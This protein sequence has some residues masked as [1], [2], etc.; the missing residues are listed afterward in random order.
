M[1]SYRHVFLLVV[2]RLFAEHL[3]SGGSVQKSCSLM[4]LEVLVLREFLKSHSRTKE[5]YLL[6]LKDLE[7]FEGLSSADWLCMSWIEPPSMRPIF[8]VLSI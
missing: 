3:E 8:E 1:E 2:H 7:L 4:S 6:F 5:S